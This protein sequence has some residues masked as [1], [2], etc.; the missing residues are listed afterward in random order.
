MVIDI[1]YLMLPLRFIWERDFPWKAGKRLVGIW[2]STLG[3][4][5]TQEVASVN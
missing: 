3:K 4:G 2:E 1:F 5:N